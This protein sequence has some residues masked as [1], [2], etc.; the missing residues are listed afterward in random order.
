M[1][2]G[3]VANGLNSSGDFCACSHVV[4]DYF[5]MRIN[6]SL[7]V[8]SAGHHAGHAADPK[9]QENVIASDQRRPRPR[10]SAHDVLAGLIGPPHPLEFC[11]VL[12]IRVHEAAL[13]AGFITVAV[14]VV[15]VFAAI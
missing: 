3:S 14:A 6:E 2:V 12:R 13:V 10:R 4:I 5:C 9:P 7:F 1:R 8:F 11:D 15:V